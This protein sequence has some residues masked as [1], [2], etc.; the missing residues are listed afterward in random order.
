MRTPSAS[1]V[2]IDSSSVRPRERAHDAVGDELV[3]GLDPDDVA[4]NDLVG[5]Q[6][7]VLRRRG[8][9]WP[10][11]AT[12]S[13]S[14]SSVSFA[15]SSWRI[16]IAELTTAIRP[17]SASANSPSASMRTKKTPMIALKSVKTL[18]ATML[19]TERLVAGSAESQPR[20]AR[21][22]LGATQALRL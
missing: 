9:P 13:A 6:L 4:G 1:P 22:C 20:E 3:A 12:S 17:K 21:R 7:D 2:S 11:G 19:A 15:F 14:W 8:S 16:P 18:P 5:A 10:C